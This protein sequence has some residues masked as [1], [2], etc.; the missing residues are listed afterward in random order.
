MRTRSLW[1]GNS[2]RLTLLLLA[3]AV[4]PAATLVWLGLQLLQQDRAL[5]A[6]R[7]LERRQVATQSA[8]RS[9]EQSLAEAERRYFDEAVPDGIV[10]FRVSAQRIDAQPMDRVLWLPVSPPMP[11][12]ED[13]RFA[14]A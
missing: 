2:R 6:Q 4:P 12:A 8:I 11:A 3:V 5:F 1:R 9:L 7:D 13:R 14:D 10:R